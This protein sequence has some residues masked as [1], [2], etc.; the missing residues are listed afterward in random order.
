MLTFV[1]FIDLV[2]NYVWKI[3]NKQIGRRTLFI[4]RFLHQT[5]SKNDCIC[6]YLTCISNDDLFFAQIRTKGGR[7]IAKKIFK[8]LCWK[9]FKNPCS[10]ANP[11][12]SWS[13]IFNDFVESLFNIMWQCWINLLCCVCLVLNAESALSYSFLSFCTSALSYHCNNRCLRGFPFKYFHW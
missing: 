6:I 5:F 7:R 4:F 9:K 12:K 11:S 8:C 2:P 1:V 3:Y 10:R 13:W